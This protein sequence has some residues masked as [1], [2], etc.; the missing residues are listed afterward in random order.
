LYVHGVPGSSDDWAAFLDA[1]GGVALDLPGFGRS[2]RPAEFNYSIDGIGQL[3]ERFV[4][5]VRLDQVT[6]VLHAWG[7]AALSFARRRPE[8]VRRLIVINAIP[9]FDSYRWH[10]VARWWRRPVI[11]ETMM[12]TTG[13]KLL[14]ARLQAANPTL[15]AEFVA[16]L[17]SHFDGGSKRAIL[18]LYR[19]ADRSEL[20]SAS[21]WLSELTMP[22][23]VLWGDR[24]PYAGPEFADAYAAALPNADLVHFP[25]AGHW[26][27]IEEPAL[28]DRV[29][30]F[31]SEA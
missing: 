10:G 20:G 26:P 5:Q 7:G 2:G 14:S 28:I 3:V 12:L 4:D 8:R 25:Q 31:A 9:L 18:D 30:S 27:W 15:P 17:T 6:L 24:D 21:Q 13:R 16:G 29:A 23:L 1:V 19:S 11:G 22:A